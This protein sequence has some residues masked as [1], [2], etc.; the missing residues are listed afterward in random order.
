MHPIFY[1]DLVFYEPYHYFCVKNTVFQVLKQYGFADWLIH[2][3]INVQFEAH[4]KMKNQQFFI[5]QRISTLPFSISDIT[6]VKKGMEFAEGLEACKIQLSKNAAVIASADTYYLPYRVEYGKNHACHSI[7]ITD[8][9]DT[10]VYLVDWYPPHFYKGALSMEQWQLAWDSKNPYDHNPFSGNPIDQEWFTVDIALCKQ[11]APELRKK[12]VESIF[13]RNNTI[14]SMQ[15]LIKILSFNVLKIDKQQTLQFHDALFLH[16]RSSRQ[17]ILFL[18]SLAGLKEHVDGKE[19]LYI[20]YEM[21]K[22]LERINNQLLFASAGVMQRRID[23]IISGLK[24]YIGHREKLTLNMKSV[25]KGICDE[26]RNDITIGYP[27]NYL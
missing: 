7:I 6:D 15:L 9:T 14:R 22:L 21:S 4:I 18:E 26:Q 10:Y 23:K 8:I 1:D 27:P 19:I 2:Q 20:F 25:L 12:N 13:E 11:Y 16:Y 3:L 17:A 24:A 5:D